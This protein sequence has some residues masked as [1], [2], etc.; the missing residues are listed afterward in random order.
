MKR[1]VEKGT[2]QKKKVCALRA[3]IADEYPE[4]VPKPLEVMWDDIQVYP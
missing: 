3:F 4:D 1:V 2:T